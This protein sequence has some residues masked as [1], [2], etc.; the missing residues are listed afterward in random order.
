MRFFSINPPLVSYKPVISEI[1]YTTKRN[2]QGYF[3]YTQRKYNLLLKL[4]WY[5]NT[6]Y[7]LFPTCSGKFRKVTMSVNLN[8]IGS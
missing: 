7:S 5:F 3:K 6:Y 2:S 8:H 1:V 4:K